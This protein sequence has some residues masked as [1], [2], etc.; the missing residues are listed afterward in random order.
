[1]GIA[2]SAALSRGRNEEYRAQV[3]MSHGSWGLGTRPSRDMAVGRVR[4]K[5]PHPRPDA[6]ELDADLT[7]LGKSFRLRRAP[8]E[9]AHSN[10]DF[11]GHQF[12]VT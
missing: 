10:A 3:R 8:S 5:R 6:G 9:S 7:L 12:I 4:I 2:G 1:M 11:D